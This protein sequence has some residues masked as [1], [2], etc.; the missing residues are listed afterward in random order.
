MDSLTAIPSPTAADA[1]ESGSA[2][3][4]EIAATAVRVESAEA[5]PNRP[6]SGAADLSLR[7][8]DPPR[9]VARLEDVLSVDRRP[10][11]ETRA[12]ADAA[13]GLEISIRRDGRVSVPPPRPRVARLEEVL[14]VDPKDRIAARTAAAAV[15]EVEAPRPE[16][17]PSVPAPSYLPAYALRAAFLF[18]QSAAFKADDD[19]EETTVEAPEPVVLAAPQLEPEPQAVE[20]A[21]EATSQSNWVV[22]LCLLALIALV[23]VLTGRRPCRC[24]GN[25]G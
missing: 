8:G 7:A 1:A 14:K 3:A 11:D 22:A 9:E 21:P 2:A 24:S 17:K 13:N 20:A 4:S 18:E 6:A 12:H 16:A 19:E 25:A 5:E 10:V 15:P 23:V